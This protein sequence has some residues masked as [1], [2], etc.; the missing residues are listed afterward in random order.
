MAFLCV[1]PCFR[2]L[3]SRCE[4][5]A[6]CDHS[7]CLLDLNLPLTSL[8]Y[9]YYDNLTFFSSRFVLFIFYLNF[10]LDTFLTFR[11][12]SL[13][14]SEIGLG[15]RSELMKIVPERGLDAEERPK[16]L[17]SCC[18]IHHHDSLA[19]HALFSPSSRIPCCDLP[20]WFEPKV[21]QNIKYFFL[22]HNFAF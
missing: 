10:S 20:A 8:T 7:V 17:I 16:A 22:G 14:S 19:P 5:I 12:N 11:T 18:L 3:I 21:M 2:S 4:V 13:P 6:R 9:H 1:S 15:G